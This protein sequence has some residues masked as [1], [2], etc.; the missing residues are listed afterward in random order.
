MHSRIP[1]SAAQPP[2]HPRNR[3]LHRTC[4]ARTG[5]YVS[6]AIACLMA[7]ASLVVIP[8]SG[9]AEV[10]QGSLASYEKSAVS[11]GLNPTVTITSKVAS[12]N[13]SYQTENSSS[14]TCCAAATA[15]VDYTSKS[16]DTNITV[17]GVGTTFAIFLS[18]TE[19]NVVEHDERFNLKVV[20]SDGTNTETK[21]LE[22]RI[23][24]D[25]QATITVSDTTVSEG[26]ELSFTATLD[27]ALPS[28][29]T[30][31]P[32]YTHGTATAADYTANTSSITFAGT[33]GEKK[34]FKVSTTEDGEAEGNEQFTVGL[35][36]SSNTPP[37][38]YDGSGGAIAVSSG[39]GTIEN[40]DTAPTVAISGPTDAQTGAFTA[41]ISFSESVTGFEQG[42]V[43]VGNG[44]VTG[45]SGSG[46]AYSATI[47]PSASGTV[48]VDVAAGVATNSGGTGNTA[49]SRYSVQANLNAP[50]I[51]SPG[52]KTYAPGEA[53]TAFGITVTDAD[54]DDVTVTVSG[55]PSGLSYTNGQVQ[56]T[57]SAS[58]PEQ[59]Y[60]VT[61]SASDGVNA[62]VTATFTIAVEPPNS[63]P[64][65]TTPGNKTYEQGETITA[66]GIKVDDVDGDEVTV[67]VTGL[68][69]G[70][71]YTNSQVQG[72]VSASAA[73]QHYTVTISADDGV[74]DAVTATFTITVGASNS[75]PEMTIPGNKTYT[76]GETIAAFGFKV[77]DDDGDE[78][79]VTVSGLPEGLSYTNARVQGTVSAS[80]ATQEYTVTV[81]ADDGVNAAVTAT[82]TITVNA[83]NDPPVITSPGNKS[84]EQGE[85]IASF[86][87]KVTDP[88]GD[89][90]TVTVSGL[91]AGLFYRWGKVQGAVSA[92]AAV[93]DYKVT[94]SAV[95]RVNE[96]VTA[97]FTITVTAASTPPA[98]RSPA[99]A[100]PG[101][102]KYQQGEPITA[103]GITTTDAD[104]DA[105]TV[106]VSGLPSGLSYTN[107]QVQGTVSASASAQAYTVTV[108]ADDGVNA[109]VTATF[110]ITVTAA[111][112]PPEITAPAD[113]TYGQ[114]ETISAFG[115]PVTDAEGDGL[116]M[117]IVGLPS[118]LTWSWDE[119][120][121]S[122]QVAGTVASTAAAQDYTVTVEV[123]EV[124]NGLKA[125]ASF[126]ITVTSDRPTVTIR[127]PTSAQTGAFIVSIRF[128]EFVTG[129]EKAD[130]NV[131]NGRV[132]GFAGSGGTASVI[133]TPAAGGTVTVDVAANVAQDDD[134][135]GNT[136]ASRYSVHANLNPPVITIPYDYSTV[137]YTEQGFY[138]IQDRPID[139]YAILVSD[140]DGDDVTVTVTGLPPGLSYSDGAV[141]GTPMANQ[142]LIPA[143]QGR[144]YTPVTIKADDG[145]HPA[146]TRTVG[147]SVRWGQARIT[148]PGDRTYQRG[149]A[150]AAFDVTVEIDETVGTVDVAGLPSGLYYANGQIQ[151]TVS[152][153]AAAK[154]YTVT[155]SADHDG[156]SGWV[157]KTAT[158]TITVA[159]GN[160][161]PVI[162][163]PLVTYGIQDQEIW[164]FDIP[165]TDPDGDDVTVTV[166]GLPPGLSYSDGQVSGTPMADEPMIPAHSDNYFKY[167]VAADDGVNPVVTRTFDYFVH[168]GR[169]RI[170]VPDDKTYQQG[171]EIEAFDITVV[172]DARYKT[173]EVTG[174]PP[175]LSYSNEQVQG[176]VSA[177]AEA[178][179][180]TVAI[181]ADG[182]GPDERYSF[183]PTTKT[184]TI[185]V[186]EAVVVTITGPA[187]A[188]NGAFDVTITFSEPVT[189]FEQGD[190]AVGNGSV[191]ALSGSGASYTATVAPASSGTVTIDV[192]A[193]VAT[194]SAG[195]GHEAA[196]QFSVEVFL[197]RS[198]RFEGPTTLRTTEDPFKIRAI[199]SEAP[200][201]YSFEPWNCTMSYTGDGPAFDLTLTPGYTIEDNRKGS[202]P[203][204]CRVKVTWF[205]IANG[206][207]TLRV[208]Y[209]VEVDADPPRFWYN[210]GITG[211]TA[212]QK[213]PFDVRLGVTEGNLVGFA[214]E[215]ITVVNGSVTSFEADTDYGWNYTV[216]ITPAASGIVRVSVGA[217]TFRDLA[218]WDN[219]A[220]R[221]YSVL[222][223]LDAPIVTLNG[224]TDTQNGPF[225]VTI[226]FSEDVTGF[227]KGD[228]TVGNGTVTAF[229]GSGDRYT[230]TIAPAASGPVTVGVAAATAA[231]RV[232]RSNTAASQYSVQADLDA[233]AVTLSG[234]TETQNGPFDATI[235]FSEDVTGFLQGDV[236]VGNG[237][238][239]AFSGSG[240]SYTATI[241][242]VE[243]GTVTVDVTARVARDSAGNGNTAATRLS[244]QADVDRPSVSIT[245]PAD[246][247]T[248]AF[249]AT[250]TFSED[251]TGFEKGD[252]TVGNGT[253]TAFSGTGAAYTATVKPSTT[254]LVTL[255]VAANAAEDAVGNG[256][257]VA[258][259][260]SVTASL[261]ASNPALEIIDPGDKTYAQGETIT[262]FGIPVINVGVG[263]SPGGAKRAFSDPDSVTV[264]EGQLP[265]VTVGGLPSGLSYTS[266]KVQGT[267]S[268]DAAVKTY[269]VAINA[270][271]VNGQ[272][273]EATFKITV[274][275]ATE[276]TV[277]DATAVEGEAL[278]FSVRLADA[279]PG[280]LTVTP[281][282]GDG[283]ASADADYT[284]D[285][286]PL[287]FTGTAGE[288][289]TFTVPTIE[290][291]VVEAAE[292]FAVSL[293][294][295]GTTA[296][297]TA[298]DTATGTITDDD[299]GVSAPSVTVSD[300]TAVEGEALS[301][302]VRLARAV[303]GGLTV[304]PAFGDVTATSGV[305]YT[306]NTSALS[307]IG[308]AGE[309][310]TFTVSTIEDTLAEGD[311]TFTL[312][313]A[314]SDAPSGV[315]AGRA[316]GTITDD[317]DNRKRDV[318]GEPTLTVSDESALEGEAFSFTVRLAREVQGGFTVTP[319]FSD[320]TATS[321][322]DYTE[323][324]SSLS[325]TGTAGEERTFTVSTIE[326]EA[327]EEDETFTVKLTAPN[328]PSGVTLGDPATC[329]I[330]DDDG[331]VYVSIH[332]PEGP[333]TEGSSVALPV[334]I[335]SSVE[336]TVRVPWTTSG[337]TS[338]SKLGAASKISGHARQLGHEHEPIS[339]TVTLA[340]GQM[341]AAIEIEILDDEEHEDLESFG[342]SLGEPSVASE[343]SRTVL[344]NRRTARVTILDDDAP[345]VFDEGDSATRSVAENT[346]QGTAIGAPIVATDAENDP[347]AYTLSGANASAFILDRDT[348]QLRTKEP[349]DFEVRN[350]YDGLTVTVDD[351]HGHTDVL[352]L[353]VNVTDV[354]P[355]DA[356]D[357]PAVAP[358]SID[359]TTALDVN[360]TAPAENGAPITEYDVRYREAG[361]TAWR[362]HALNGA[363]ASTTVTGL[364]ATTT[365]EVQV[366]AR[367]SEGAGDWSDSGRGA[368][369][370]PSALRET[371]TIANA[372]AVEGEALTFTVTLNRA[373]QGGLTVTPGFDDVS[374][375]EGADYT[376]NESPL[377]FSG[378][379]GEAHTFTVTTTQDGV[380][381]ND[382][383][384]AVSLGIS[385]T[386][387]SGL[388]SG[389]ATG[390]IVDD[391]GGTK[392]GS[393]TATIGDARA[394]GSG[395][396]NGDANAN[397]SANTTGNAKAREGDGLTFKVTLHR[398]VQGGLTLRPV[399]SDGTATSGIDYTP[400]ASPLHFSGAAGEAHTFTVATTEDE[401]LEDNETFTVGLRISN[402]PSG[403]TVGDPATGTIIDD[404]GSNEP[405]A[406]D[407]GHATTRAVAEN[408]PAGGPVG[409]PI[410]ATDPNGD[411]LNYTLTGSDAFEIDSHT[412][413]IT[414]S[415]GVSLDYEAGPLSYAVTVT[416]NDGR[417]GS[418]VIEVAISVTDAAEPPA[419]P[420]APKV[421]GASLASVQVNWH[422]P[423]NTGP[424]ISDY[425]VQ[426]RKKGAADWVSHAFTGTKTVT[427][428]P[429]LAS[430]GSYE[431]Q[432]RA[433]NAEGAG[434]WSA[435][436]SGRT[437]V[438][439]AP[440]AVD[441]AVTV[442]RGRRTNLLRG[443]N[444]EKNSG[445]P[446][447][448]PPDDF[449]LPE[450]DAGAKI[451]PLAK[452]ISATESD[453]GN[454]SVLANDVD[455]EDARNQLT[456]ILVDPPTHGELTLYVNGTFDYN[457]DGSRVAE[458]RFTYRVEDSRGAS[459]DV[460]TVTITV[461]GVNLGPAVVGTIPDQVLT[462]GKNGKVDLTGLFTD[463]DGDPLKYEASPGNAIVNVSL[464]NKVIALTPLAVA[465]T[466]VTVT[467]R[468]PYGLSAKLSFAVTVEN[469]QTNRAR[470]LELSLAAFGR[471]VLS[472]AVDAIA[473][474]FE[475]TSRALRATLDGSRLVLGQAFNTME[476]VHVAARLF[477]IPLDAP[478]SRSAL[479][480][481][482]P[483]GLHGVT[484]GPNADRPTLRAPSGRS[485]LTRS[486]F[487]MAMDRSGSEERGW[488]LWGRGAGSRYSGDSGSGNRMDGRVTAAYV[489]ADYHWG[490]KLVLGLAASYSNGLQDFDNAGNSMGKWKTRLN[491][492][493]PYFHW[494]PNGKL[495]LWGMLGFGRG[496]AV[497][498]SGY[499]GPLAGTGSSTVETDISSRS[500][501][502]GGRMDM[503][504]VRNVDLA[505]TA[506]AFAVS[507]VSEAVAGLRAA[508][509]DARRIRMMVNGGT[510]WS[511]TPDTRMDLSLALGA[512]VDG[513]DVESGLGAE[514]AGALSL[515]NRRIG[516]DVEVRS[517]WL[518]AHQDR[519][520]KEGGL[521]LAL[522][523]DPGSDKKGLAMSLAPEWG[524]NAASGVES[525]W[526][527]ERMTAYHN[528][529]D[530]RGALGWR[531]NRT[532]AA[533]GYG[534]EAWGGRGR[535][536]PFVEL[537]V[538]DLGLHRL[539]GGLRLNVPGASDGSSGALTSN[540]QLQLRG[541][542]RLP[543]QDS[544]ID[545]SRAGVGSPDYR[546]GLSLFRNF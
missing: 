407:N 418:D 441:D 286:T 21:W 22:M 425:D 373:V 125:T 446:R 343:V 303:Q 340:A 196:S 68:P 464:V 140:A 408:T 350:T 347:L 34:T 409:G 496:A 18:T 368:T 249:D 445:T 189:G 528:R 235:T 24:N 403:V 144:E 296:T 104:G 15:G 331:A 178:K 67:T 475:A 378:A 316:T 404:D 421:T 532:R 270:T 281:V 223:D 443:G 59:E 215:D 1:A 540:L 100:S 392:G 388:S 143:F 101:N 234:P 79:T 478:A 504:R 92:S 489:G 247:Q 78:V 182:D 354:S 537:D 272:F 287:G 93:K 36:V 306:E 520:F 85:S 374:A 438:N 87:F 16:N 279:V 481:A 282:F 158:F 444:G 499:G 401:V 112:S 94:V 66:F 170:T 439:T 381:E 426:F 370:D 121:K 337:S 397:G 69:S 6:T 252:V 236:T 345:P 199:F 108:S 341:K 157:P 463:P 74:N 442:F 451:A 195:N 258:D 251:V 298:T 47:T 2:I 412:G 413:Q 139:P 166:T 394:A 229:S 492:L 398:A 320:V 190:V 351:G 422:A 455:A 304:T 477:G 46:A 20:V 518:A 208:E 541:E 37:W 89:L 225:D 91:P 244:V 164:P 506:D 454:I 280:G 515:S 198:I 544:G 535:M 275:A 45:F 191:T 243:N 12:L 545:G 120:S 328:A 525:L 26:G 155:I 3:K 417:E 124:N 480:T 35:T 514:L 300:A 474:R 273:D 106:T 539:G 156:P 361:T 495:G 138:C 302:A 222:A 526:K 240:D 51:T 449:E 185:S 150:I 188:Q 396:G 289:K 221:T 259:R 107:G 14:G 365:Y 336:G 41:T 367:N 363:G 510:G 324:T 470:V 428:I 332:D 483:D 491:S 147:I 205:G 163:T 137:P 471:T 187:D 174:L 232:N 472:Q 180:Y 213:G 149:E 529:R 96:A 387:T 453:D 60:T 176:T 23:L 168:Y 490:S 505:L 325:F 30:V 424:P 344:V 268:A 10:I 527:G 533:L 102:K 220:S 253:V 246:T 43:T 201:S 274:T 142:P 391:D 131:G 114:G 448:P 534:L 53:I 486:S 119:A 17:L 284:P 50:V 433:K 423:A 61:I 248:G 204:P 184:F 460:A 262:S 264:I 82:F 115:I 231:D 241:T 371:V 202:W 255:D 203:Y 447:V 461:T 349:L 105:V 90:V 485:I 503:A 497:L 362:D 214:A 134:G 376:A 200:E 103:F 276:V 450:P 293:V 406:F 307:F 542:Y 136:A 429:G 389:A 476:W 357:A 523:L 500:A 333:V 377:S 56:G 427:T 165:V 88:E 364:T 227:E 339:G 400:N 239:T 436:G 355:P 32:A 116:G 294:V 71:S 28:G 512:R 192:P 452:S 257:T 415:E 80:A 49:A 217:A 209:K 130:V 206:P 511:V 265:T 19:D 109:S 146:V 52:K 546:V 435:P 416:V 501:A 456:A 494:S 141:R 285:T 319:V 434:A 502:L 479:E 4:H 329:T 278:S 64:E 167:T 466:R 175:G 493:H 76:Q 58:A 197:P 311:E 536:E 385:G 70:L 522:R 11:E 211:P 5:A 77:T 193:D 317:D 216:Q 160:R 310:R 314:V 524:E 315:S 261:N 312:S 242:P 218:G 484:S 469:V 245:G 65:I 498:N 44:S 383:T 318:G 521:S 129:F 440:V 517:H 473:G 132:T 369:L 291:E 159:V 420:A 228:V 73:E 352:S 327:E 290:D 519:D 297:V 250:I 543:R 482:A 516:L 384:F 271:N 462:M 411:V 254:G 487:R 33:A 393:P 207:P 154:D 513:G 233:P 95:D 27:K 288:E 390:T 465:T 330:E 338:A 75:A 458:D 238:V 530:G 334:R 181:T 39:T 210:S 414:V 437:R 25:D 7:A 99:I 405:P 212:P 186:T 313:L 55:L 358:S 468:D 230:A 183:S 509:G 457:H 342:I 118:G 179:D 402:A 111:N 360:W 57:V 335:T 148:V 128:S 531:P 538:E 359:P 48:T 431:A 97:T 38:N 162:G 305:D 135:N 346:P 84:Y 277:S 299:G 169:P 395:N 123:N 173:V 263:K 410:D 62:A 126:T 42:D 81:S 399:F 83:P 171:E 86:G 459:S 269:N 260:F 152:A 226:T 375:V 267:V 72:T 151:G 161:P 348:G 323:N 256:N 133:I 194:N 219:K 292:T 321:G 54:N 295:S 356:P 301:F 380:V 379:A 508:A 63:A 266:R 326:D 117:T 372:D 224:P 386:S 177:D 283:T 9:G 13:V 153:G 172:A 145:V 507:T 488:T 353:T 122:L 322:T 31:T 430:E 308:A 40:D 366:L 382:E 113:K 309:E 110:T 8:T 419:A 98:N 432:V 127:G 237:T 467:A 29:A